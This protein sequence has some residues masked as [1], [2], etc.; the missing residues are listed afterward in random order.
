M[1]NPS[2]LLGQRIAKAPEFE[3]SYFNVISLIEN[4][5]NPFEINC[6]DKKQR[7]LGKIT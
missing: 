6:K 7:N 2:H 1:Q 5:T 3:I 4:P